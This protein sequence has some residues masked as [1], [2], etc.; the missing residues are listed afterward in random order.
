MDSDYFMEKFD[1]G[2]LGDD[3]DLFDW[4]SAKRGLDTWSKGL[5]IIS[6]IKI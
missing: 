5:K 2:D 4:Y 3:D 6:A 1:S